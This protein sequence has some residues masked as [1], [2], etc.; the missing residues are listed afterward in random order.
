MSSQRFILLIFFVLARPAPAAE[1]RT[2]TEEEALKRLGETPAALS[3]VLEAERSYADAGREGLWP[4]PEF[5]YSREESL[6]VSDDF[7]TFR[8]TLPI[9]GLRGLRRDAADTAAEAS[10]ER[11]RFRRL[12]L[13]SDVRTAFYD[14]LLSQQRSA[15]L[16]E[17]RDRMQELV[18][19][20]RVRESAGESSGYDRMR[21]E[22]ELAEVDVERMEE[23]RNEDRARMVLSGL[24]AVEPDVELRAEGDLTIPSEI[25]PLEELL[26]RAGKRGDVTAFE[27]E[28]ESAELRQR[29]ASRSAIP[30]PTLEIGTKKTA[31]SPVEGWG[32][33]FSLNV[34]IPVFNRGQRDGVLAEAERALARARREAQLRMARAEIEAAHRNVERRREAE[35]LYRRA[36]DPDELVSIA[37]IAYDEGEQG[38]LELLDAYRTALRVE[39]RMLVL[40]TEA[41]KARIFLDLVIG[42]EVFP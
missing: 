29:A 12:A 19:I 33:I 4:N 6:G 14:L 17:G 3:L 18:R 21:A 2:I 31:T 13:K 39:L 34:P 7:F 27:L 8:Q 36:S 40:A 11:L 1:R 10:V 41:R 28:G 15:S 16:S 5:F 25:P 20:L 30:E 9:T 23:L 24:L 26:T 38:I 42:E 37:R 35:E 22:R 32:P